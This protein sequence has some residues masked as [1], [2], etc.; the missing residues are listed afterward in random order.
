M[1]P[2]LPRRPEASARE[3]IER[4]LESLDLAY[5]EL[6]ADGIV[7]AWNGGSER[8]LGIGAAE[9]LGTEYAALIPPERAGELRKAMDKLRRGRGVPPFETQRQHR[10]GRMI[11][12]LCAPH[13]RTGADGAFI[14]AYLTLRDISAGKQAERR[15]RQSTAE[16][17]AIVKTVIDGIVT[18]DERGIV[19]SF[20]PAAERIF[21]YRA[22]EVI[23]RNV[24]LLMPE[25]TR[26]EHD[27]YLERYLRTGVPHVIGIG[28][29][30]TGVNKDGKLLPLELAIA[31][32]LVGGRR[33]FV[34]VLHDISERKQ[35]EQELRDL[36]SEL[37]DK[38]RELGETVARLR[39][40]QEQ[41]VQSEK[42]AS[43]GALVAGVAHEINTPIGICVTA[44][45]F[46][47][48]AVND[49]TQKAAHG[50]FGGERLAGF[51]AQVN[52]AASLLAS[53]TR[54]ASSLIGSFK[55]VA[56]DRSSAEARKFDLKTF[57]DEL[58]P[59]L[60]PALRR[61]RVV[62]QCEESIQ[63]VSHA[64]ALAQVLTNLLVNAAQHAFPGERTGTIRITAVRD[65][66]GALLEVADDGVGIAPDNLKRVFD[67]FF[68]T[69]RHR[70]GT[71][72]GLHIAY[73]L[74]TQAL[75]G[76]IAAESQPG[77][78]ARFT[79]SLPL[80]APATPAT[81]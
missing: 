4:L 30:V 73:N 23:G 79:L 64:G 31:P 61:H 43:L 72:L 16:I 34:G 53:N 67:P 63:L 7:R 13:A 35:A 80:T 38:V 45:S 27:G 59:S 21:G 51:V 17:E 20:N 26:G 68:T 57:L 32:M 49:A 3:V 22:H 24:K 9:A 41:L 81:A 48:E 56:V 14:G 11:D 69:A 50:E 76:T 6:D 44:A 54:R 8:L 36:N 5:A 46:L 1:D 52:E 77:H 39:E 58:L 60:R 25:P 12:V 18:I 42:M 62:V 19:E 47:Q 71:G 70:G 40:T 10:D 65:G 33:A 74:V 15:L 37:R 29:E 78:G 55:Q 28:R 2:T 66:D 75:G